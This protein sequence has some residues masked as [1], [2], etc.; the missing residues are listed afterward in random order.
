[1]PDRRTAT[2][3]AC[4]FAGIVCACALTT[5]AAD[6]PTPAAATPERL[7]F[8]EQKIRPVL[9]E[10][11]YKC[12]GPEAAEAGKLKGG[13]RLDSREALLKGGE[14]GKPSVVPGNAEGSLLIRALRHTDPDLQMPPKKKLGDRQIA[15]FVA[16][17]N[18][19]APD[20]RVAAATTGAPKGAGPADAKSHWAFQALKD[21]PVPEVKAVAWKRTPIDAFVLAKLEEKNVAPSPEADKRTLIRRATYDLTG[22]PPTPQEVDAF[23]ADSSPDAYDNLVDRLLASPRFGERWGRYWLDLARYSDTKGYVYGDREEAQFVH[24]HAYR[25]W[26]IKALN[27]DL[28]YDQFLLKQLAADQ[29]EAKPAGAGTSPAAADHADLA[30]MGFLTVGRRFLGIPHDII[31]DRIDV[32]TRTTQGLTVACARCHDHKFDPIPTAD[33]YSLYGVFANSSERVAPIVS[34]P[35]QTKE[36]AEYLA[37]LKKRTEKLESTFQAKRD[38]MVDRLRRRAPDYLVA[39]LDADKMPNELFYE[40]VDP[41]DLNRIVIRQWQQ[42]LFHRGRSGFDPVFA[43]W[44]ALAALP[45][46]EFNTKAPETIKAL[47]ADEKNKLNPLVAKAFSGAAPASMKDVAVAYGKLF[48]DADKTWREMHENPTL[49]GLPDA[50]KEQIRQ[51]VY[52]PDSPATIPNGAIVDVEWFFPES[53]RVELGKLQKEIDNLNISHPGAP[54]H[55]VYL[56]DRETSIVKPRVFKRGNPAT[57]GEEVPIQYLSVV[58]GEKREP[59]SHGSGRLEMAKAIASPFNPLTAR[60][61]VNRIWAWH[62]GTGLVTTPSD[63]GTRCEPPSHPELLDWLARRFVADGWSIKKLNRLIM[64][65][66][67]FR[68][69]ASG[70]NPASA[71]ADPANK[72][73]WHFNR[74]RLDFEAMR[75]SLLFVS[76]ELDPTPGGRPVEMFNSTRRSVYGKVDRQFLPGVFRVFDFANP[77]LHIPSRPSTT[78]PQQALFFMNSAF[79]ADRAKALAA[80]PEMA[81][82][83]TPADGVRQLYRLA[84]QRDPTPQQVRTALAFVEASGASTPKPPPPKPVVTAWQYGFGE[85]DPATKKL[86]SFE[87]LGHFT[88]KAWQGGIEWPDTKLGWVQLTAEGG[89]AGND[90]AHAAVRRWTAPRDAT[91]AIRGSIRHAHPEGDGITASIVSTRDGVLASYTLHNQSAGGGLEPI[92]VKKGDT[93]DFVVD[94]RANLN[95]DDFHWA[96]TIEALDKSE[97][98]KSEAWDAQKDFGGNTP[99]P[100]AP[101]NAWEQ[102]AQVLLE[103]N[104]FLFVD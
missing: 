50:D 37:E 60:V 94:F 4:L 54:D 34:Q 27:D 77:D 100:P 45:A 33:Y 79:V 66:A 68:E 91:V 65:S 87:R 51:V 24:A 38:G 71:S 1:M 98:G 103:S 93:I 16:W 86:K 10:A 62:F 12:H 11:C 52:G 84:L 19:G 43:V 25:D 73:L 44:H 82:A 55:A 58:T 61:M 70:D 39:V 102:L 2:I 97:A 104:E 21:A 89:H 36:Y 18:L 96:P 69:A 47:L 6:A 83:S 90:L 88:G 32:V 13:L 67:V 64:T 35:A 20:P 57:K 63:F 78:V 99:P 5:S 42:Y 92:T 29:L 101:L 76:G 56:V 81:K 17:V 41:D 30:A 85:I 74:Q 49:T 9:V 48:A 22:L 95:N 80:R 53:T 40:N 75:D 46:N 28:P 72:L 26:V 59:F 3:A 14:S 7:E 8:F 15:D 31:D 23:V